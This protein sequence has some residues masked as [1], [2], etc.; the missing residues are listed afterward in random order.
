MTTETKSVAEL[1]TDLKGAFETKLD[2]VKAFA[3][4]A[5]GKA[6]SNEQLTASQKEQIDGALTEMNELKSAFSELEQ[7]MTRGG[8]RDEAPKTPGHRFAPLAR[9]NLCCSWHA[10]V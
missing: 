7:K 10:P 5:L 2:E 8:G 3:E 1:A 4:D 6:K 9:C